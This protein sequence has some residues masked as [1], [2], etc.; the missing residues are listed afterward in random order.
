M[1][2]GHYARHIELLLLPLH[3]HPPSPGHCRSLPVRRVT[4]QHRPLYAV[5]SGVMSGCSFQEAPRKIDPQR[6]IANLSE[7]R[8]GCLLSSEP[9]ARL[10]QCFHGLCQQ[11]RGSVQEFGNG[12]EQQVARLLHGCADLRKPVGRFNH[13]LSNASC[14]CLGYQ[15]STGSYRIGLIASVM[16]LRRQ[17]SHTVLPVGPKGRHRAGETS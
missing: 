4:H 17:G 8:R 5:P 10:G 15:P 6:Q 12:S 11:T 3:S 1:Q 7:D 9:F 14:Q 2:N 13:S 16:V